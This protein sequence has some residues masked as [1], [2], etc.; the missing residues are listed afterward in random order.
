[1]SQNSK[2]MPRNAN[3]QNIRGNP[4][5]FVVLLDFATVDAEDIESAVAWW[6]KNA[7]HSWV[8]ALDSSPIVV[9]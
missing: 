9:R 8:G 4:L 7:S 3:N 6:D 1:M 2:N 5:D